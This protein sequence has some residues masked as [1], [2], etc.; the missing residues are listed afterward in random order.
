[1]I[2]AGLAAVVG[3]CQVA[4]LSLSCHATARAAG[5][6]DEPPPVQRVLLRPNQ[7][8]A[9]LERVQRGVLRQM[10]RAAFDDL[11][12]QALAGGGDLR[13]PP[14]LLQARY[15]ASLT[16]NGLVGSA[17]WIVRHD[18]SRPG[19]LSVNPWQLAVRGARWADGPAA[20]LGQLDH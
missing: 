19:L 15:R 16:E 7:L 12:R 20:L 6:D 13:P 8:A 17:E 11:L 5:P 9:E 4:S 2:A 3:F 18:G 10:P 14:R 1:T